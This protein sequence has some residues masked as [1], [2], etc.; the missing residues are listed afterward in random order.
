[1]RKY[2]KKYELFDEFRLKYDFNAKKVRQFDLEGNVIKDWPSI[3]DA[4]KTLN[5]KSI[6]RAA[7][8][9]KRSAGGYIWRY[10]D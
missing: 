6:S 2:L 7:N 8:N 10:I 1:M 9:E 3:A 4:E 5:I